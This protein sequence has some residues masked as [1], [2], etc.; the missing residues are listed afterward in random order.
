MSPARPYTGLSWTYLEHPSL[1]P[2]YYLL[3]EHG[4]CN[5]IGV[6]GEAELY[7]EMGKLVVALGVCWFAAS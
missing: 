7:L 3:V 5:D 6:V 2:G 1:Q 4:D